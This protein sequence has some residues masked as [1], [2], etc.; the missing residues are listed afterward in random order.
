MSNARY[1]TR[2]ARDANEAVLVTH[3]FG[4]MCYLDFSHESA[5]WRDTEDG[6]FSVVDVNNFLMETFRT[7]R[8]VEDDGDG[9]TYVQ[10]DT[11]DRIRVFRNENKR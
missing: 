9:Y 1:L 3:G 10:H 5:R 4:L 8:V 11:S 2:L 6:W 7:P